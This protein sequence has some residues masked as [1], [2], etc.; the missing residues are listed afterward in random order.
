MI[1]A[2]AVRNLTALV[3]AAL[4]ALTKAVRRSIFGVCPSH[5][6][7]PASFVSHLTRAVQHA[8]SPFSRLEPSE[9][10]RLA[11]SRTASKTS[12]L[13]PTGRISFAK[14]AE[15][16][17]VPD[18]LDLQIDSFDWLVG[19]DAWRT[20]VDSALADGRTDINT[21][22]G[23]EEIFEEISPIEDFS[24][25]MS[26]SFRDHRFEPPKNT[27]DD[28]KER[29]VTYAAP[30][31]VTAEFMNNETGEIKSQTVFMGDFPLM[32]DKGTF[33]I[34]GTERVVVSQLVRS[35]GVYF[36]QT[37]DKTSDK[38]IFTCKIIPSRGAWLEFEI[39]KRD[40]VGVRLDRKRKQNVTV[41]LK[42]LG[43]TDAQILEEFGDYESMRL[44][45]EKD[46]TTT[47]DEALL[48]IYRKLRPGEPPTREAA[49]TLL[50]NYYFNPKRYDLAKVGRYKINKKLGTH[51]AFDQ[52]TLTVDDIVATIRFIVELHA[53]KETLVDAKGKPIKAVSGAPIEVRPDDID[54]FGNRR[55][56]TV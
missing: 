45:L 41:L 55:M 6:V 33:V 37:T 31:F 40:M 23:L 22:S 5:P 42:A 13:T 43:W 46:H 38:D 21:K 12:A 16:M 15:P 27:V 51:E 56:R 32:T 24:G 35:P 34:N 36:E 11:A 8:R 1:A 28:C 25:T 19:N 39:D 47:Q 30:L 10:R 4:W 52:Q 18:L 9:D 14:I 2:K 50:Q 53:G 44:T 3:F 54:H 7:D 26:L 49:Q 48:D 17:E 20:K 29:D